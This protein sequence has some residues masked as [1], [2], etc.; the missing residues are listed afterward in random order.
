MMSVSVCAE[1]DSIK[2][3]LWEAVQIFISLRLNIA[4]CVPNSLTLT[5][6]R[7]TNLHPRLMSHPVPSASSV[8][9]GRFLV[10]E[11]R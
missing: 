10:L 8:I 5:P 4:S 2:P 11:S 1:I 9:R 3:N 7:T 6:I